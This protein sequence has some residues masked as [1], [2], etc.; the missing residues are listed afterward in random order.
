MQSKIDD[1]SK[2]IKEQIKTT[3]VG[4]FGYGK[5]KDKQSKVKWTISA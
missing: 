2:I 3:K 4:I 1:I 5:K